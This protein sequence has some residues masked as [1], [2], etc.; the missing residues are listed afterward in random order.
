MHLGEI[1]V[2]YYFCVFYMQTTSIVGCNF[3][4]AYKGSVDITPVKLVL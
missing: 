3:L 1:Q 4:Q 2:K